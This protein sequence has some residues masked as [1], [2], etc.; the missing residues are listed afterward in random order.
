MQN[1]LNKNMIMWLVKW[2]KFHEKTILIVLVDAY[3]KLSSLDTNKN[4]LATRFNNKHALNLIKED[5]LLKKYKSFIVF[6]TSSLN[7]YRKYR[8]KWEF[9]LIFRKMKQML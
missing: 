1:K 4:S 5:I 2:N 8:D 6:L 9:Q 3:C 7:I